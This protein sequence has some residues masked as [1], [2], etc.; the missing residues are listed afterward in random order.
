MTIPHDLDRM[1]APGLEALAEGRW[2]EARAALQAVANVQQ[3]P[4]AHEGL[5]WAAWW[6]GDQAATLGAR[7]RASR[8][9]NE[10]DDSRGA[11][12]MAAWLGSDH[13]EF[14]GNQEAA[15]KWL[16]RAA[17]A[18]GPI[19]ACPERGL[20]ALLEADILLANGEP[21]AAARRAEQALGYVRELRE[22]P[23]EIAGMAV[24]GSAHVA[25]A[26][27]DRGMAELDEAASAAIAS[28]AA[29]PVT[30]GWALTRSVSTAV[31]L[32]DI[33][34]ATQWC[35]ALQAMAERW[36]APHLLA[37]CRTARAGV[38]T[39]TGDWP[40][41]ERE[42]NV[43]LRDLQQARPPL[44][45]LTSARLGL[46]R[47]KQGRIDEARHL[48]EASLPLPQAQ[49]GIGEISLQ[50]R[51][52][53]AAVDAAERVLAR[54]P[55]AGVLAR[56]PALEL[57]A[58][59]RAA[60]QEPRA[61]RTVAG[62]VQRD[63]A[64]LGTLYKRGRAQLVMA[65]VLLLAGEAEPARRTALDAA[66]TFGRC[67]APYEAACAQLLLGGALNALDDAAGAGAAL[68]AGR[69]GLDRLGVMT[70]EQAATADLSAL[71]KRELVV[72]RLMGQGMSDEQI[73]QRLFLSP[74]TVHHLVGGL[75]A[76]LRMSSR[77][78]LADYAARA[79]IV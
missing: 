54:L 45:T 1:L 57:L 11:A 5:S 25:D 51:Q 35:D 9:Y 62:M 46:L 50:R 56:L 3:A 47:V 29:D 32:G 44:A 43:A 73:A 70:T 18:I 68:Q 37:I 52:P 30:A 72:M 66:E 36:S 19:G 61:A 21:E 14:T 63:A 79:G 76:K 28:Q 15:T 67:S 6:R 71:G 23:L 60:A 38:Q 13:L 59:A 12:R 4:Q 8:A 41:A 7:E 22:R 39:I 26:F 24:L 53:R 55:E 42:L 34:R 2:A 78:G 49:V 77:E 27:V 20:I 17:A 75:L 16:R 74:D 10:A 58:R 33:T 69:E 40:A 64:Q 31:E 65:E 48:L